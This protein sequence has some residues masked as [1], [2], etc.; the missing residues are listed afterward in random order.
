[1]TI[2]GEIALLE[3]VEL[4]DAD[5][6]E[7]LDGEERIV[8][9]AAYLAGAGIDPSRWLHTGDLLEQQLLVKAATGVYRRRETEQH[10]L[11]VEIANKVGE[12]LGL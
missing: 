9:T 5:A 2:T 11:A 1:M 4:P 10:N 3:L 8:E 7:E 12:R 6:L